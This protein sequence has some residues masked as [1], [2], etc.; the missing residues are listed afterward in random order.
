MGGNFMRA[1]IIALTI[2]LIM[3]GLSPVQADMVLDWN[4]YALEAISDG[5]RL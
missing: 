2:T 1:I 4:N 3:A 5:S